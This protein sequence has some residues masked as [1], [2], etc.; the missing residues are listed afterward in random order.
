MVLCH[1]PDCW[2]KFCELKS[3]GCGDWKLVNC[4]SGRICFDCSGSGI[5]RST[6]TW[7]EIEKKEVDE[8]C[9]T[10]IIGFV[11]VSKAS[12]WFWSVEDNGI[13][14]ENSWKNDYFELMV[15]FEFL[16]NEDDP[17][18]GIPWKQCLPCHDWELLVNRWLFCVFFSGP[19]SET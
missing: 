6:K 7:K 19:W 10:V 18:G 16:I 11:V 17:S 3:A 9:W 15:D 5:S 13:E 2:P 1:D 4:F 8:L 14:L 12:F